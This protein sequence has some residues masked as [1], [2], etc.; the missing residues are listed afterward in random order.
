MKKLAMFAVAAAALVFA[1]GKVE[2]AG[3]LVLTISGSVQYQYSSSITVGK[4]KTVSFSNATIYNMLSNSIANESNGLAAT[5]PAKGIIKYDPEDS[6]GKTTGFF[7]VT[8]KTN[9]FYYPLSGYDNNSAYYSF[10][11]LD[12]Y[13]IITNGYDLDLGFGYPYDGSANYTLNAAGSGS[14]SGKDTAMLFVHDNPYVYD[15]SESPNN[16]YEYD[17][18]DYGSEYIY[19]AFEIQGLMTVSLTYKTGSINGGSLSLTGVG[20]AMVNGQDQASVISG[21]ASLK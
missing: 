8:D 5:L 16:L 15:L 18:P 21:K 10:M 13:I 19:N 12:A 4:T 17:N 20:N 2:A 14:L 11:E 1:A 9:G 3:D 7:Y 6:D